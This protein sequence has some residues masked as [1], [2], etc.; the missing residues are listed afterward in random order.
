MRP[1]AARDSSGDNGANPS[2]DTDARM[3]RALLSVSPVAKCDGTRIPLLTL[4]YEK[5]DCIGAKPCVELAARAAETGT[6]SSVHIYADAY[7]GS[8]RDDVSMRV[9]SDVVLPSLLSRGE[10]AF[11]AG[12]SPEFGANAAARA[13]AV[14]RATAFFAQQVARKP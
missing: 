6:S 2:L 4:L 13:D 7:H 8:D 11:P 12:R 3:Q 5:D 14:E 1:S 9:R 10:I